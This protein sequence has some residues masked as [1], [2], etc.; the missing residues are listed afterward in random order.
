MSHFTTAAPDQSPRTADTSGSALP[1]APDYSIDPADQALADQISNFDI[2]SDVP[3]PHTVKGNP[4][5]TAPENLSVRMLPPEAQK[6]IREKLARVPQHMQQKREHELVYAHLTE[7][8][9]QTRIKS[10]PGEGA[11]AFQKE[12]FLIAGERDQAQKEIL[13]LAE[14]LAQVRQWEPVFDENGEAVIDPQTGQ[15]KIEAINAVQGDQRAGMERRIAE[16]EH[17]VTLLDGPEGDLRER[18]ALYA[19]VQEAKSRQAQIDEEREARELGD[20]LARDERIRRRAEARA[21]AQ[22]NAL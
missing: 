19:A 1:A 15:Q 5:I 12:R 16:L 4:R 21:K 13:R 22:R 7:N 14:Q 20:T 10:G 6:A 11:N 3:S 17:K 2:M 9:R 18:K 8:S